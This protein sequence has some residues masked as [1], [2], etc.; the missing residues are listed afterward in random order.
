MKTN[1]IKQI[2]KSAN[3]DETTRKQYSLNEIQEYRKKKSRQFS[4]S[5]KRIIYFDIGFKGLLVLALLYLV[6][7]QVTEPVY[8]QIIVV[9]ASITAI[10]LGVNF[11]YL[12]TL[13]KIKETDAV[14]D[15]LKK[16]LYYF[17]N[18]YRNFIINSSL[19]NPFFV[20]TGFFFYFQFKYH[21]IR[22]GTP[23]EDPVLYLFLIAAFMISFGAQWANYRNQVKELTEA[24]E[25]L[26]DESIASLKIEE[27]RISRRR[28][29]F[30]YTILV[31]LGVL[32]LL[33][34]LL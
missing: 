11:I 10:L 9:L 12:K 14:M 32:L 33:Y 19:S 18:T 28:N 24:I 8:Q 27:H 16:Q 2:W 29:L 26:D 1:D 3:A 22:M 7:F 17:E 15:N 34:F 31:V 5:G 20:V 25:D 23:W 30:M 13:K 21:E 6:T 4:Q